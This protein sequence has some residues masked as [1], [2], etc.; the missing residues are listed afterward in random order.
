MAS[1]SNGAEGEDS[2]DIPEPATPERDF[3]DLEIEVIEDRDWDEYC[4]YVDGNW[5]NYYGEKYVNKVKKAKG[6]KRTFACAAG[7]NSARD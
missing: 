1:R 5:Y 3:R 2:F 7:S 4:Y 6:R